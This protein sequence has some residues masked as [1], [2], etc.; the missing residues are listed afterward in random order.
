MGF[1]PELS[2]AVDVLTK[3]IDATGDKR[4]RKARELVLDVAFWPRRPWWR[5]WQRKRT[6]E[7]RP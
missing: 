2:Y 7:P 3:R 4:L 1:D 5:F 6:P